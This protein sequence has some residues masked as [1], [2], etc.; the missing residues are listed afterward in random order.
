MA[1]P[2]WPYLELGA[3]EVHAQPDS[4]YEVLDRLR[5]AAASKGCDGLVLHPPRRHFTGLLGVEAV[6][7]ANCI[8]YL[9][10]PPVEGSPAPAAPLAPAATK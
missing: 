5:Q 9:T 7:L 6:H 4:G 8:V 2:A 1:P 3:F 10:P